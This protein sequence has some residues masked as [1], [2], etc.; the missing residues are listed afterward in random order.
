MNEILQF[1]KEFGSLI[2]AA[3]LIALAGAT[4][5]VLRAVI[6]NK[7]AQLA[8][9]RET[10]DSELA[11]LRKELEMTSMENVAGLYENLEK[12][13]KIHVD[14][15]RT[16]EKEMQEALEQEEKEVQTRTKQIRQMIEAWNTS[17]KE[18]TEQGKTAPYSTPTLTLSEVCGTYAITGHNPRSP[19]STYYGD[20]RIE[21]QDEVLLGTWTTG[22]KKRVHTGF[23]LLLGNTM[24]FTAIEHDLI[25]NEDRELTVASFACVLYE[26][27]TS[28][29]M[30]GYWTDSHSMGFEQGL[31]VKTDS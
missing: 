7:D 14:S 21:Q 16:L 1:F 4:T 31:K 8:L 2:N 23:G 12:L 22:K 10:K 25:K 29:V 26:F 18:Y 17:V 24:A 20:L 27:V 11:L 3:L 19:K 9:L 13:K 5:G 30:R 15:M 6:A 28:E